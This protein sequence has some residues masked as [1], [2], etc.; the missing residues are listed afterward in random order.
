MNTM[1]PGAD[2]R[3]APTGRLHPELPYRGI[4]CDH[5]YPAGECCPLCDEVPIERDDDE[6]FDRDEGDPDV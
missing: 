4:P 2:T 1:A 6:D 5:G 3:K